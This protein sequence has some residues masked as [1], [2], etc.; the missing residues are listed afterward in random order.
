MHALL[1]YAALLHITALMVIGFFVLFAASRST[2]RLKTIGNV[3]GA[4]LFVV[5]AIALICA[6]FIAVTF[7][8]RL[9]HGMMGYHHAPWMQQPGAGYTPAPPPASAPPAK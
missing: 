6:I 5:A 4:W 9:G 2:G 8:G 7:G 3:L 1:V